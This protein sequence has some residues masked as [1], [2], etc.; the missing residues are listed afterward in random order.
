MDDVV[1][2]FDDSRIQELAQLARLPKSADMSRF[3]ESV[4]WAIRNYIAKSAVPTPNALHREIAALHEAVECKQ[5]CVLAELTEKITPTAWSLLA[6]RRARFAE[7]VTSRRQI[8]GMSP[9]RGRVGAQEH[10]P[11]L[12]DSAAFRDRVRR[13][14]AARDLRA[15]VSV[16]AK[17][18]KRKRL[19][20]RPTVSLV[21]ILAV[22]GPS[23]AEP[24]REAER[25]LALWL[26]VSVAEAGAQVPHAFDPRKPGPLA[27]MIGECLAL[28]G[29]PS[30]V[31]ATG[32]AVQL[33]NDFHK[34]AKARALR[35]ARRAERDKQVEPIL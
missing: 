22:P 9:S 29:A 7:R 19:S 18:D 15:L 3:G 33:L 11:D 4:R 13:E 35:D 27:R 16:G 28:A 12:P 21:P 17:F 34:V 32:L 23:R 10:V 20:G 2:V 1:R 30:R 6:G 24:R 26:R 14:Q 5:Y 25:E 31:N 8:A